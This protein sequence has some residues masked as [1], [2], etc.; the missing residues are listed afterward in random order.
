MPRQR[1]NW[2]PHLQP[3]APHMTL[4]DGMSDARLELTIS[5]L[6]ERRTTVY[7]IGHRGCAGMPN[8]DVPDR[9]L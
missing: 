6:G 5:V 9:P 7:L 2:M 4:Q 8:G 3:Q 1:C